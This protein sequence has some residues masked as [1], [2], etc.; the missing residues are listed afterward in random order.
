VNGGDLTNVDISYEE[1][2]VDV[3]L[4]LDADHL[5]CDAEIEAAAK[6]YSSQGC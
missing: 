4:G 5:I 3:L 2:D 1:G 6:R